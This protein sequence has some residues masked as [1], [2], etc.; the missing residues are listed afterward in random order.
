MSQQLLHL[1]YTETIFVME[2]FIYY[3]KLISFRHFYL[4]SEIRNFSRKIFRILGVVAIEHKLNY[5][6]D[7]ACTGMLKLSGGVCLKLWKMLL[8]SFLV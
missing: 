6:L 1:R 2:M 5:M 8:R 7:T 3:V 4:F